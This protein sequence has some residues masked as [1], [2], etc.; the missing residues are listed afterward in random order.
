MGFSALWVLAIGSVAAQTGS[1]EVRVEDSESS[2]A[3]PGVLVILSNSRQL[4]PRTAQYTAVDG[5]TRF[6]IHRKRLLAR[7]KGAIHAQATE[8][9]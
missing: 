7:V 2:T 9:I 8:S 3:L 1:L 5:E 6:P 4:V